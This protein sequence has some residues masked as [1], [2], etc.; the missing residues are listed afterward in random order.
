MKV[1]A[2]HFLTK[3][4]QARSLLAYLSG[5]GLHGLLLVHQETFQTDCPALWN[6]TVFVYLRNLIWKCTSSAILAVITVPQVSCTVWNTIFETSR[7]A[8]HKANIVILL[9]KEKKK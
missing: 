9:G 3:T 5:E 7:K 2:D 1:S 6:E 4:P 8:R